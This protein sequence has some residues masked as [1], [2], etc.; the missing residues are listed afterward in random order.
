MRI[1]L[2]VHNF[3]KVSETFIVD[4]FLGLLERGHDVH[5]VAENHHPDV[6]AM[7]PNLAAHPGVR[8]RVHAWDRSRSLPLLI[9]AAGRLAVTM[10]TRPL[11]FLTFLSRNLRRPTAGL[12]ARLVFAAPF[13]RLRPDV[14]HFEFGGAARFRL[15]LAEDLDCPVTVSFRGWDICGDG[16]EDPEFY[17]GVWRRATRLH[18]ISNDLRD[19]A[20]ERGYDGV[21]AADIITPAVDAALS[22][23]TSRD[24]DT[25]G[26]ASRPLRV[27][28]VGRLEWKKG[29]EHALDAVRRLKD[30]GV[31][32]S[33]EVIGGG[34]LEGSLRS[35]IR[36]Q[37][38]GSVVTLRG[39]I[40][41]SEVEARLR[42]ADVF[43]H[44]AVS[45]GFC[46][47][48]LEA[49]AVGLPVVCTDAEGLAENIEDGVTG[50]LTPK[51]DA[52]ALADALEALAHDG[53]RRRAMGTAGRE[54]VLEHFRP[55]QQLDRFE[56]FYR[57]ACS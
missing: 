33:Y 8:G 26:S 40:T 17:S 31:H 24:T 5:L 28:S 46:N 48:V 53:P 20:R 37:D 29:Y 43:L 34:S 52:G 1:I 9:T 14:V 21:P 56:A 12:L 38:L 35:I 47:A 19:R 42:H 4:K 6:W 39:T 36:D 7:F 11:A 25:A 3:P 41:R 27:V 45:E 2:V 23:A 54:R 30:R 55:E 44:P 57:A 10:A 49:Q 51:E 16:I 13:L 32:L 18:F 50:I 15:A 22:P